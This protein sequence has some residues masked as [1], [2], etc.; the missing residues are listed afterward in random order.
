MQNRVFF[1]EALLDEWITEGEVDIEGDTLTLLSEGR[2]YKVAESVRIVAEVT[3]ESDGHDLVGRVKPR[4]AL[5][6]RGAE[7]LEG[8][9]IMGDNAY[10]VIPGWVGIPQGSFQAHVESLRPPPKEF[11]GEEP[12]TDEDLLARF[13]LRNLR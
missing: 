9:M 8:S 13:L 3:G 6:E 4:Q 2:R 1:P 11:E 5:E 12:R 10:D 7:I